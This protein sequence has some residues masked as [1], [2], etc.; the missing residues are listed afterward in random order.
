MTELPFGALQG[1]AVSNKGCAVCI[2]N[3][4]VEIPVWL[5]SERIKMGH[6]CLPWYALIIFLIF[7]KLCK[8]SMSQ[9]ILLN[10]I[11]FKIKKSTFLP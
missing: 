4:M 10:L 3:G 5:R 9:F 11:F 6:G 1:K 2:C 8:F 7:S